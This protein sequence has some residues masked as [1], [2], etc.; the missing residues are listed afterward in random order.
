MMTV[1]QYY[2]QQDEE[3]SCG[4]FDNYTKAREE[5]YKTN[6]MVICYEFEYSDSYLIDDFRAKDDENNES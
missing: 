6:G 2:V 4:P 1:T 3:P 5:A